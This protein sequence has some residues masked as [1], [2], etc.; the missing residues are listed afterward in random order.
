MKNFVRIF[1]GCTLLSGLG[2]SAEPAKTPASDYNHADLAIWRDEKGVFRP[3]ESPTDWKKRRADILRG[4]EAAMGPLPSRENLPSLDPKIVAQEKGDGFEKLRITILAEGEDRVPA[5]LF[6]PTRTEKQRLPAMLA[7]HQT[8]TIGKDEPAGDGP[9]V[10]L[11]YALELAR[12]G[13][14][15]LAPDY[16]SFGEYPYDFEKD[17]YVSGSMKGIFNHMRCVDYLVSREEVD[18]D[19]MGVIGHSLGGHN[20]MFVGVFDE[21][22]KVIVSSC[23]WTPFHQYYEGK[24]EGWTSLRYMPKL[25]DTYGLDPDRVPFDFHEVVAALAPRFF[26]SN[27]PLHDSN[28]ESEGVRLAE[29]NAGKVFSLLNAKDHLQVRYPD[30]EHDFPPEIRREAY[31]FVDQAF[32]HKPR[33]EIP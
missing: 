21:R 9:K 4:M 10:N 19:R 27:S 1:V 17:D 26:F 5:V 30:C 13:Y 25:K 6:L 24:I 22:L 32:E 23:G 33:I 3:I 29:K 31:R 20:S 16:P 18:P 15:T 2:N 14:V 12:R 8:T 11:K 28:F 7:L